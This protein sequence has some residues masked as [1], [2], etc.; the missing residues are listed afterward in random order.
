MG[1]PKCV[2][3]KDVATYRIHIYAFGAWIVL[4]LF[5]SA[6]NYL[7]F[8]DGFASNVLLYLGEKALLVF[9]GRPPRLENLG[10]VYPPLPYFFILIF[11]NALLASALV[12]AFGAVCF[13]AIAYVAYRKGRISKTLLGLIAVFVTFSPLSLFLLSQQMQTCLLII[14]LMQVFH[15]LFRYSKRRLS[16]DLFMFGILSSLLFF[17][18]FQ[19]IVLIPFLVG[20]LLMESGH[21]T[22]SNIWAVGFT[23]VFPSVFVAL[24]WCYL[25]QLFMKDPFYFVRWWKS[26][27]QAQLAPEQLLVASQSLIGSFI[28]AIRLCF[29][30]SMILL[31]YGVIIARLVCKKY[32]RKTLLVSMIITPF[33]LLWWQIVAGNLE[34][35]EHFLLLF[36]ATALFVYIRTTDVKKEDVFDRIFTFSVVLALIGSFIL[37]LKYGSREEKIFT[38]KLLGIPVEGNLLAYEKLLNRIDRKSM[39]L[40]DD[41][42]LFP[43][44][45]LDKNPR[46]FYLPYEYEYEMYLS[47]PHL[48]VRYLVISRDRSRDRLAGMAP[49]ASLGLVPHFRLLGKF[50]DAFL[51]E[52]NICPPTRNSP[53]Q[54]VSQLR[55]KNLKFPPR[56]ESSQGE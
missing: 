38:Q 16:F 55:I 23:G 44:V 50:G 10:F 2:S 45:F 17:T 14:F 42:R 48:Y 28:Y 9:H 39:V 8:K 30:N 20:A 4:A 46:R 54:Q 33:L 49:E 22:R 25:N 31:P 41:T 56:G 13:L 3:E 11:R 21:M 24:S 52:K 40:L 35:S 29:E 47:A 27:L 1:S 19:A 43:L 15:H 51:F 18:Q 5:F 7:L 53:L 32:E 12:G 36:L 37:P 26:A 6:I 34:L